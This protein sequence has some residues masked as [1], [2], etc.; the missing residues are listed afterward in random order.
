MLA[1][2][3]ALLA[4]AVVQAGVVEREIDY[5]SQNVSL[6]GF[7]AY[8]DSIQGRR[9]GVLV[10]HEWWGHNDYAR[11]RT[12]M[13]AKLGYVALAVDMYGDGKVAAH[14]DDAKKFSAEI[15]QNLPLAK[16]RFLAA[17]N[18]L[19][20]QP[21]VDTDRVAAIGYCF[22]GAIVLEMARAGMDLDAVV[23]F[24]GSLSAQQPA[25]PGKVQARILVAHGG[26]DPMVSDEQMT[27]FIHEMNQAG[28]DFQINVY[29]G[30]GHSF[31]NPAADE[32]GARFNL[33]L[34]YDRQADEASWQAMRTLLDEVFYRSPAG[35]E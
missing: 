4:G 5:E 11:E 16:A 35:S 12:R 6:K 3:V 30:A 8:D 33:P 27:A 7:V 32:Y 13:L 18:A 34:K 10:V 15:K 19:N 14:P 21:T 31:T 9:P 23:S 22:G 17:L 20:L 1:L 26:A 29:E 24:H 28:A 25:Q 2:M